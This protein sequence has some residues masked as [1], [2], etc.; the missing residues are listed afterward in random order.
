MIVDLRIY[1]C[2]P[3][4]VAEFVAHYNHARLHSAIGYVTPADKLAG[5]E[6]GDLRRTRPQARGGPRAPGGAAPRS[7]SV[8]RV[9]QRN[10][11]KG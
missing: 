8:G 9:R 10:A 1:T 11:E 6:P 4:R 5:R 3:N 2:L 7:C